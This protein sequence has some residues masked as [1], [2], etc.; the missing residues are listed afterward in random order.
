MRMACVERLSGIMDCARSRFVPCLTGALLLMVLVVSCDS[1]QGVA[2]V[3]GSNGPQVS[4]R[5]SVAGSP[6][7]DGRQRRCV[8][9]RSGM[10]VV[11]GRAYLLAVPSNPPPS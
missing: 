10:Y 8:T 7:T 6:R 2:G 9:A 11:A 4:E 3:A 1:G 5:S